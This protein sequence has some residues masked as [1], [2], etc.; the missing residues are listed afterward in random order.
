M[1]QT[2]RVIVLPEAFDDLDRI[3]EHIAKDSPQ[4]AATTLDRLWEACQSLDLL[5]HRHRVH[6]HR[7]EAAR[8]VHAMPQAP[9]IIYYRIDDD[10]HTVRVLTIRHGARRQPRRF[11]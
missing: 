9:F 5:P 11:K 6:Q 3:V 1:P 8:S 4:N 2:Y 7:Q 10:Q